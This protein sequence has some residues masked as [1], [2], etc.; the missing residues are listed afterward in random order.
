M[1]KIS[2]CTAVMNR[3][4]HIK[5]TLKK[6]ILDNLDYANLEF[7]LLDYN[8][9]DGLEKWV[10][11]EMK[12]FLNSGQLKF[13]KTNKPTFFHRSHSRNLAFLLATG[14]IVCNV[15]A[16]NFIG[17]SFAK[18]IHDAF[19]GNENII[20]SSIPF[21]ENHYP[22][23]KPDHNTMGRI[24]CTKKAFTTVNGYD[25]RFLSY[26]FEDFDLV[27]RIELS[28]YK[29]ILIPHFYLKSIPHLNSLRIEN[30][31]INKYTIA[32]VARYIS[33][34]ATE[35][36]FFKI[37]ND[38]E[39]FT[40]IN[41]T[42]RNSLDRQLAYQS[43]PIEL[44]LII[45]NCKIE[46]GKWSSLH[47]AKY[48]LYYTKSGISKNIVIYSVKDQ[49]QPN[50]ATYFKYSN[51]QFIDNLIVELSLVFNQTLMLDN[52]KQK[53]IVAN[54]PNFKIENERYSVSI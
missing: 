50:N 32:I 22:N 47:K 20:L 9:S 48:T 27:N 15:D 17:K 54:N 34:S 21:P 29:R 33:P 46:V 51:K 36:I 45:D 6:N 23:Y 3:L 5:Q 30:D 14:D 43:N 52:W 44:Q 37:D 13:Y 2:F 25:E 1:F 18:Y 12:E 53:I 38:F 11:D 16:D 26:G 10:R 35:F 8:S 42:L 40:I 7:V 39:S 4:D 24:V 19:V 31:F 41:T 28:G 49:V